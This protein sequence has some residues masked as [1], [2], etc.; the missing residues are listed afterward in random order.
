MTCTCPL[1]PHRLLEQMPQA[2]VPP[3]VA[4]TAAEV[5]QMLGVSRNTVYGWIERGGLECF[6]SG[7]VIRITRS[8]LDRFLEARDAA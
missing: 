4:W 1:C 6:R 8:Q 7:A 2:T 5:A 3:R